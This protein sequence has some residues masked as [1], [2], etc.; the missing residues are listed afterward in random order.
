[1]ERLNSG[2]MKGKVEEMNKNMLQNSKTK[3]LI[4]AFRWFNIVLSTP[5]NSFG[6]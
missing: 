5:K 6:R 1:V 4:V 3:I 2:G